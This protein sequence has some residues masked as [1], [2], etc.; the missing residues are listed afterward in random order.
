MGLLW[1]W[2]APNK[3]M[4]PDQAMGSVSR[5]IALLFIGSIIKKVQTLQPEKMIALGK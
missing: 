2:G 4:K 5:V 3:K 1:P